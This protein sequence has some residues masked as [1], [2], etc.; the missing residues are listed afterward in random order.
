MEAQGDSGPP[1]DMAHYLLGRH[2]GSMPKETR[3]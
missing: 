2:H 3:N 1:L